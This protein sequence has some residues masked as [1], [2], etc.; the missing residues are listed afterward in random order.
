MNKQERHHAH[1]A[2]FS[3]LLYFMSIGLVSVRAVLSLCD[4]SMFEYVAP[5]P[6]LCEIQQLHRT[7]AIHPTMKRYCTA[8]VVS[9]C[10]HPYIHHLLTYLLTHIAAL[11]HKDHRHHLVLCSVVVST[12]QASCRLLQLEALQKPLCQYTS[13]CI[14]CCCCC[15]CLL[16]L[17][18]V[19]LL[20]VIYSSKRW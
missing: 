7:H 2:Q 11:Q 13:F 12:I 8:L 5:S 9:R 3:L 20:L 16:L 17:L 18:L 14:C 6:Q 10:A 1:P 19:L 15:V 4:A